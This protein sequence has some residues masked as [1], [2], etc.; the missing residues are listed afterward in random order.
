[1][2]EQSDRATEAHS[3]SRIPIRENLNIELSGFWVAA[4]LRD[5]L[6]K[7]ER[8]CYWNFHTESLLLRPA[9]RSYACEVFYNLTGLFRGKVYEKE[10]EER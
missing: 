6:L 3:H 5:F 2:D 4:L 9:N 8:L 1:M 7:I 10:T